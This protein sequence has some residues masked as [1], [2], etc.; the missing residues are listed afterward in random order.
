MDRYGARDQQ[1]TNNTLRDGLLALLRD[2]STQSLADTR[3]KR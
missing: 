3:T 1:T 2:C